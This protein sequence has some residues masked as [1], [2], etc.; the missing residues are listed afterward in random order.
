MKRR[1]VH[2][3]ERGCRTKLRQPRFK[4]GFDTGVT[5]GSGTDR[6]VFGQED[7]G[8][9]LHGG[10]LHRAHDGGVCA[11]V[12]DDHQIPGLQMRHPDIGGDDVH[13]GAEAAHQVHGF[14][15]F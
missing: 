14:A 8:R 6:S 10:E 4:N 7:L 11:G 2:E 5:D 1:I 12:G 13:P 9:F 3:S 15:V